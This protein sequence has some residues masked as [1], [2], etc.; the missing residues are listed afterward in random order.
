MI[1]FYTRLVYTIRQPLGQQCLQEEFESLQL[2]QSQLYHR[3]PLDNHCLLGRKVDTSHELILNRIGRGFQMRLRIQFYTRLACTIQQLL[4]QQC[5][6]EEFEFLQLVQ[7]QR[8]TGI[9]LMSQ[10]IMAIQRFTM[11]ELQLHQL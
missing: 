1:Q 7:L 9:H 5:L 3:E 10:Q 6:Q 8:T 2:E 4:G 11:V